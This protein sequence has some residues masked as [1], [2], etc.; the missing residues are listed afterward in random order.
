MANKYDLKTWN[1]IALASTSGGSAGTNVG[2]DAIASGKTRFLTY[3]RVVRKSMSPTGGASGVSVRIGSTATSA[4]STGDLVPASGLKMKVAMPSVDA[5]SGVA[6]VVVVAEVKGSLENPILSVGGSACM[7][8][9]VSGP[10]V[11][12]FAQYYDE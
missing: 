11:N 7:G 2:S 5:A 12:V 3:I 8:L 1:G 9:I 10:D 4:P 6:D